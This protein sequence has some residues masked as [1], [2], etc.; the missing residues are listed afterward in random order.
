[1][2][3][4]NLKKNK[5]ILLEYFLHVEHRMMLNGRK[6]LKVISLSSISML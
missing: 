2:V 4:G 6:I 1:M 3:V 5:K